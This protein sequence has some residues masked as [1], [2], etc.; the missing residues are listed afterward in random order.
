MFTTLGLW[1]GENLKCDRE[2]RKA[3]KISSWEVK[4]DNVE[5]EAGNAICI[6]RKCD[7]HKSAVTRKFQALLQNQTLVNYLMRIIRESLQ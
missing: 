2:T 7:L 6:C 4:M 1:K 5:V 3:L